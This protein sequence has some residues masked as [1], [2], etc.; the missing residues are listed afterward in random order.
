MVE[1]LTAWMSVDRAERALRAGGLSDGASALA[2]PLVSRAAQAL[3]ESGV[4]GNLASSAWWVPGRVEILGKHT[5]YAGGRSLTCAA[6]RGFA[7]VFVTCQERTLTVHATDENETARFALF[8]EGAP[9]AGW[10]LYASTLANRFAQDASNLQWGVECALASNLPRDAGLSSSSALLIALFQAVA[11]ANGRFEGTPLGE[12][13]ATPEG[14]AAY[15]AS[16]EAGRPFAGLGG[17]AP[18]GVGT[19]GG[20]EDHVAILCSRVDAIGLYRYRPIERLGSYPLPGEWLIAVGGSGVSAHKAGAAR[21]AYNRASDLMARLQAGE[22]PVDDALKHRQAHFDFEDGHAVPSAAEALRSGDLETF[23]DWVNRS[24][25]MGAG[26]L[27]NQIPETIALAASARAV[28]S[29]CATAFGAGFGGSVW[30][31][32]RREDPEGFLERWRARYATE[33]EY[34]AGNGRFFTM[35]PGPPAFRLG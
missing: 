21:E 34:S 25:S 11:S 13:T 6:E 24:Q 27:G 4:S 10:R 19:R 32:I 18:T 30:A 9:Q 28:G 16:V 26:L 14:Q 5:D 20:S 29:P 12:A 17:A 22:P 31:L 3:V 33:F 8:E 15:L 23:A 1:P 7:L 2:A 35:R